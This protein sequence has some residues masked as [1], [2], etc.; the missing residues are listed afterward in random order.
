MRHPRTHWLFQQVQ[1]W[2]SARIISE[3]QAE[4]IRNRYLSQAFVMGRKSLAAIIWSVLGLFSLILGVVLVIAN[5]WP[6]I[7]WWLRLLI[8]VLPLVGSWVALG[9]MIWK[10]QTGPAWRE[11]V[12]IANL[13]GLV[14]A[15]ALVCQMY[16]VPISAGTFFMT[17]ILASLPIVWITQSIGWMIGTGLMM[18]VA[19]ADAEGL[20]LRLGILILATVMVAIPDTVF[21]KH[22]DW[23]RLALGWCVT[24]GFTA[25]LIWVSEA[26]HPSAFMILP[27]IV[28]STMVGVWLYTDTQWTVRKPMIAAAVTGLFLTL[29]LGSFPTIWDEWISTSVVETPVFITI[30]GGLLGFQLS[31]FVVGKTHWFRWVLMVPSLVFLLGVMVYK[32]LPIWVFPTLYLLILIAFLTAAVRYGVLIHRRWWINGG[33]VGFVLIMLAKF[34]GADLPMSIRAAAFLLSGS[35]LIGIGYRLNQWTWPRR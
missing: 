30:L 19:L 9:V 10:K 3:Y 25:A 27:A 21:R 13:I 20:V 18:N 8:A 17:V 33:L 15:L 24:L 14:V 26:L 35:V 28:W 31:V 1:E 2:Q 7:P 4:A 32:F 23:L 29:F 11:S 5:G 16:N 6:A 22:N 34:F 12:G